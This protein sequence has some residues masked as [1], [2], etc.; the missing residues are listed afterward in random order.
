MATCGLGV[1]FTK[2]PAIDQW[3]LHR[4]DPARRDAQEER[5]HSLEGGALWIEMKLFDMVPLISGHLA[6]SP[7]SPRPGPHADRQP[8]A[9]TPPAA[10]RCRRHRLQQAES[11]SREKPVGWSDN[12]RNV[13]TNKPAMNSTTK[14]KVNL[15]GDGSVH[16]TPAAAALVSAF[17][18]ADRLNTRRTKRG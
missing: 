13:E 5:Q 8:P 4:S 7:R 2:I 12:R 15:Q 11:P 1:G 6:M 18:R 17:Q 9:A 10:D 3:N 16:Q 14:Q